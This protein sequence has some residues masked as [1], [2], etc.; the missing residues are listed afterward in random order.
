LF[1]RLYHFRV[2][3]NTLNR[4]NYNTLRRVEMPNT[5]SALV[6]INFVEAL[7]FRDRIVWALWFTDVTVDAFI[8]DY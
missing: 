6:G 1:L 8:G 4:A 7:T 5:F 3:R 2:L